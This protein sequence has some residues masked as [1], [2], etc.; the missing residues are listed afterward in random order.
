MFWWNKNGFETSHYVTRG[1]W[2]VLSLPYLTK[3]CD[4]QILSVK[5]ITYSYPFWVVN[6][7]EALFIISSHA[8]RVDTFWDLRKTEKFEH[9]E[10]IKYLQLKGMTLSQILET[11]Q[12]TSEED[13]LL[14]AADKCWVSQLKRGKKGVEVEP[15]SRRPSTAATS[16]NNDLV[17]EMVM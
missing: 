9:R 16:E 14:Y 5:Y 8:L 17:L 4:N 12:G 6:S 3:R 10:A 7:L 1:D 11:L 13:G 15:R 2:K